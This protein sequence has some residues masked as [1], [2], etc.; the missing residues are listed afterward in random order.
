MIIYFTAHRRKTMDSFDEQIIKRQLSAK[1]YAIV[2]ATVVL[3]LVVLISTLLVNPLLLPIAAILLCVAVYFIITSRNLEFEY[4]VT[5][6][7]ITID[8]IINKQKRKSV[9]S[10][11]A[12]EIESMGRYGPDVNRKNA[13]KVIFA[14][15]KANAGSWYFTAHS[16]KSGSVFV[17]FD[18]NDKILKDIKPFLRGQVAVNAFIR[19]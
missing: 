7:S 4:S 19:H 1:D 6:G 15:E 2:A 17:V 18:P 13:G 11:E 9:I 10:I 8:K 16:Q 3:S 14:S 5:N 12:Q